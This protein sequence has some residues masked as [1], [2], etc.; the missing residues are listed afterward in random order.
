MLS[1]NAACLLTP[2]TISVMNSFRQLLTNGPVH[3][4]EAEAPAWHVRLVIAPVCLHVAGQPSQ[5]AIPLLNCCLSFMMVSIS[6]LL[7]VGRM[8]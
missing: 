6:L 3:L 7:M 5:Q 4:F 1:L 2:V 8:R